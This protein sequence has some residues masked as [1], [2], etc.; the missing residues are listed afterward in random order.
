MGL[1]SGTQLGQYEIAS[2]LSQGGMGEVLR[3]GYNAKVRGGN[4]GYGTW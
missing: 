4:N 2:P 3:A 1:A